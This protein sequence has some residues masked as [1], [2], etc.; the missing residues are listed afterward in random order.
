MARKALIVNITGENQGV[1]LPPLVKALSNTL[2]LL[3][4][5]DA[6]AAHGK[7]PRIHW[8][9]ESIVMQSPYRMSIVGESSLGDAAVD[10]VLR[11]VVAGTRAINERA[12]QP[13]FFSQET[14]G[15]AKRLGLLLNKGLTRIRF[16]YDGEVAEP[17]QHLVANVD[18]LLQPKYQAKTSL[19]GRLEEVDVHKGAEF[20]IYSEV[21]GEAV[22]CLF[23]K[24]QTSKVGALL[25]KR[26]MVSGRANYNQLHRVVSMR[27]EDYQEVPEQA[28]LPRL[29]DL[30]NLGIDFGK[31]RSED[32]VRGIRDDDE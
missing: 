32:L 28:D 6:E 20:R 26:V 7:Q 9:V 12:V 18:A 14:M 13:P 5:V 22:K 16:E 21:T 29:E 23:S 2:K 17:T 25:G 19:R 10:R 4:S 3:E 15:L 11:P 24:E 27:V 8:Q 1:G 31:G 30:R